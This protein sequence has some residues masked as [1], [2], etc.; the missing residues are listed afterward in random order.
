MEAVRISRIPE[1]AITQ[2]DLAALWG[3]SVKSVERWR[4]AGE[5]EGVRLGARWSITVASANRFFEA[6]RCAR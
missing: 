1:P 6:R 5:L 3:V 2:A 4:Q